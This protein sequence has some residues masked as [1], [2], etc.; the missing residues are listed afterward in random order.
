[1]FDEGTQDELARALLRRRGN[2]PDALRSEWEG[3]RQVDDA[4]IRNAYA[5]TPTAAQDLP[6]TE[7]QQ[8]QIDL[9]NRQTEARRNLNASIQEGLDKARLEQSIAGMSENQKRVELQL[10]QYQQEAKRAG[11]VLSDKEIEQMR[12][13]LELTGN[14]ETEG[15]QA[16]EEQT[17][18]Q[19]AGMFFGQQFTQSLSGLLTGTTSVTDAVRNLANAL[20]D[21]SLQAMLLGQGPLAALFGT[22]ESGGL[23]GAL[24]GY[25]EGG[26][27]GPG[28]KHQPAGIVHKG[29]VVWSQRDVARAG[30]VDAVEAMRRGAL[31]GF[32]EGGYV[33]AAPASLRTPDLKP[34][35][36]NVAPAQ[37]INISA[38]ITINGSAGTPEQNT[39]LAQKMAKQMEMT[40]R[41][42]V[43][44]EVRK[45]SRPG[46]Y[47][48]QRGR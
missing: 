41:T 12:Q 3:L 26:Y 31:A 29:E 40:M 24:F 32:A 22:S 25:A 13:K 8:Q 11:I 10:F 20:V 18:M 23:F 39:D 9:A 6:P 37:E 15:R 2:D 7:A 47:L 34:A 44:D 35:N 27:T 5:N 46:N 1:M 21:A 28:A 19:Q 36:S 14:L 48:Y 42:V 45:Q 38:P 16:Q 33:G 17:A 43:A 4:T 30:G